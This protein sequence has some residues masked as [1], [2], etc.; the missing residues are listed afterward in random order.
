MGN[1]VKQL[2][3]DIEKDSSLVARIDKFLGGQ[4]GRR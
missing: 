2:R 4:D 1:I 3:E